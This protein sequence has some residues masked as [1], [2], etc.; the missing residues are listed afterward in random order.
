VLPVEWSLPARHDLAE[1]FTYI[2]HF[3]P[4]AAERMRER[5]EG[6]ASIISHM[7][8]SFKKGR[9]SGTREYVAHP[10]Y[11]VVYEVDSHR[12]KVLRVIHSR[13]PWPEST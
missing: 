8:H 10:N 7:P 13:R 6:S 5:I 4:R 9:V 2:E 11:I 3:D 12:V 1:I